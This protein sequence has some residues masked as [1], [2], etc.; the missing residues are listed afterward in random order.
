M[1][2]KRLSWSLS[3]LQTLFNPSTTHNIILIIC[4]ICTT[5]NNECRKKNSK[6]QNVKTTIQKKKEPND[7]EK[8]PNYK[9]VCRTYHHNLTLFNSQVVISYA[10]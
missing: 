3:F 8:K 6:K 9:H 5:I 10:T 2:L 7:K 1:T 4:H